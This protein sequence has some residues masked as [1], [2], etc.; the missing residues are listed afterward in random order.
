MPLLFHALAYFLTVIVYIVFLPV[1][2][3]YRRL[4]VGSAIQD[5]IGIFSFSSNAFVVFGLIL[6]LIGVAALLL[7][8][9][10]L[11]FQIKRKTKPIVST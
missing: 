1:A 8:F 10:D 6:E 11:F 5:A 9:A 4:L 3:F 2:F 7:R